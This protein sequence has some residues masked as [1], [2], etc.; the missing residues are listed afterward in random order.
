MNIKF[1]MKESKMKENEEKSKSKE[2]TEIISYMYGAKTRQE[3][4]EVLYD[5]EYLDDKLCL[6]EIMASMTDN[7]VFEWY[8]K[9]MGEYIAKELGLI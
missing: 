7:E 6:D 2:L 4:W 8:P 1:L 9:I 3:I 5:T